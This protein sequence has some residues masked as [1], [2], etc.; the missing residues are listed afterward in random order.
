MGRFRVTAVDSQSGARAGRLELGH[1]I[2]NTPAFMPVASGGSVKGLTPQQLAETGTEMILVNAYHLLLRPGPATI[3]AVGGV[4]RFCGWENP[5]LSDSGGYQLHS[6]AKLVRIDDQGVE[7]RSH[8]DG[9]KWEVT[10]ETMIEVQEQLGVDIAMVL[11]HCLSLPSEEEKISQ[12]VRRTSL[13]ARRSAAARRRPDQ[14]VFGIVQGGVNLSERRRSAADITSVD[15]DGFAV[16]GLLVGEPKYLTYETAA[17]TAAWLPRDHPRYF[18]GAGAPEDLIDLVGFGFDLFD[19]VLPTRNAR[20]GQL[21]TSRGRIV[22]SHA[23]HA[24]AEEPVDAACSCYTCTHF[25]RAYL[26]HLVLSREPLAVTLLTLHNVYFYQALMR[27][28]REAIRAGRFSA[29]ARGFLAEAGNRPGEESCS[30]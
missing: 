26:R 13:W 27:Q 19:C 6:M 10:P 11:D 12:A 3:V 18:M 23:A 16:G 24:R 7:F 22:I 29:F 8:V 9:A 28:A 20:N 30:V 1:G 14:A 15:F 4:H 21:F 25:T 17:A 5:V 2:V